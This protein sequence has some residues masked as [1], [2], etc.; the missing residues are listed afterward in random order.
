MSNQIDQLEQRNADIRKA[1]QAG[2]TLDSLAKRYGLTL[3]KVRQ[4]ID[5]GDGKPES[6][7]TDPFKGLPPK[8]IKSLR[9]SG[10]NSLDEAQKLSEAELAGVKNIGADTARKI[11]EWKS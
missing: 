8:I 6:R 5:S 4:I 3:D 7:N 9:H 11:K 1:K 10:I 2:E